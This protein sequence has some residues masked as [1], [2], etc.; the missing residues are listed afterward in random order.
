MGICTGVTSRYYPGDN[1]KL[2]KPMQV[3]R[4]SAGSWEETQVWFFYV[5]ANLTGD[6]MNILYKELIEKT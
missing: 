4:R 2:N 5:D 1:N 3:Y 6:K